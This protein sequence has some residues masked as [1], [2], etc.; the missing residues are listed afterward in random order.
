MTVIA[1]TGGFG[2][3]K[4]TVACMFQVLGAEVIDIDALV[5]E[6]EQLDQSAWKKIVKEFGSTV[7]K[8]DKTINRPA[9]AS[10]VFSNQKLLQKLN[11]IVHPLVLAKMREQ[12]SFLREKKPFLIVVDIP[13]LFEVQ[14][15]KQFDKIVVVKANDTM[16]QERIV[17]ER[18]LSAIEI[19]QRIHAQLPLEQ[20]ENQADFVIDNNNGLEKTREQVKSV[21][22]VLKPK[23]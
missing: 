15:Q 3:G 12:I 20:K 6:L 7:L 2:T 9:L 4:T 13:L 21:F 17:K 23:K 19:N 1:V 16:V 8:P 18:Q 10:I 22:Y 5:R 11:A 14:E